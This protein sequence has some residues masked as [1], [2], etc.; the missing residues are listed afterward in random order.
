[1][2]RLSIGDVVAEFT[3]IGDEVFIDWRIKKDVN[4]KIYNL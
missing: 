1:M 3:H 4:I 2:A